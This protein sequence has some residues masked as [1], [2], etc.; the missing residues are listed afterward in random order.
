MNVDGQN[1]RPFTEGSSIDTEP[2][3]SPDGQYIYFTSDRGGN[4]QIYRKPVVG[5]SAERVSFG[6]AYAVSPAVSP[7]NDQLAY[8]TWQPAM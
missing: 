5:G 2:A 4:P 7:K 8:R 6:N 1:V 3:F